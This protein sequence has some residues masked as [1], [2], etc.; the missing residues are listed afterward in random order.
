MSI[1]FLPA[2]AQW[3]LGVSFPPLPRQPSRR[4]VNLRPPQPGSSKTCAEE[5]PETLS[6]GSTDSYCSLDRR[7]AILKVLRS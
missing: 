1:G 4:F 3:A 2:C 7:V 5:R 6:Q